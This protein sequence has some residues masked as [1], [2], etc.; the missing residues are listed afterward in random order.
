LV[1]GFVDWLV[2]QAG[3]DGMDRLYFLAREGQSIKLAYDR[4][5]QAFGGG[6]P[7]QYLVLSR[8]ATTVP[9][10]NSYRDILGIART[11]YVA[12]AARCFLEER[13]GLSLSTKRWDEIYRRSGWSPERQ[14]EVWNGRIGRDVLQ[15]LYAI[16]DDVF[17]QAA[18]ERP[19]LQAYLRDIGL[20][21]AERMAIV[22]VGFS[23]TVQD[24]LSLLANKKIHGYYMMT[25]AQANAVRDR[26]GSIVRGCFAEGVR[27]GQSASPMFQNSFTLEKMLGCNDAQVVR[28]I[29]Q[30]D[31][32]PL[33]IHRPLS[34]AERHGN[35][36]RT[37]IQKGMLEYT[38]DAIKARKNLFP[39][40]RPPRVL[41]EEMFAAFIAALSPP[42]KEVLD[43]LVSDA[44]YCGQGLA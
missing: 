9:A 15:L 18:A 30:E 34:E 29:L 24:R 33:G 27:N 6:P 5:V 7:S 4:W 3:R 2:E 22:D 37:D 20:E 42:E 28:Y 23:A 43:T 25:V 32:R 14:V 12:N 16:Q 40:F 17:T 21:S 13:F 35:Q 1:L 11:N 31:G 36:A 10:V 39:A 26:H 19:T 8:R 38:E 44:H 41:P